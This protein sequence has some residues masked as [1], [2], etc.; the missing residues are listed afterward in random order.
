[1]AALGVNKGNPKY[2]PDTLAA[3]IRPRMRRETIKFR[4]TPQI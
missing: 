4:K 2:F 3:K 1:L